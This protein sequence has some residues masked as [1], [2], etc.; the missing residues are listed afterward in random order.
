MGKSINEAYNLLE[1]MT[2]NS[3]QWLYQRMVPRKVIGVLDID[4]LTSLV[5][6]VHLLSK[7]FDAF[8]VNVMQSPTVTCDFGGDNHANSQCLEIAHN[9]VNFNQ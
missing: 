9:V 4:S 8:E 1:K 6:Q 7:K 2:S 5:T 3:Y